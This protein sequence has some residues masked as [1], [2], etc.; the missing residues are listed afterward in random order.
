MFHKFKVSND[1]LGIFYMLLCDNYHIIISDVQYYAIKILADDKEKKH[2]TYQYVGDFK[3]EELQIITSG[4][5]LIYD[6]YNISQILIKRPHDKW[7]TLYDKVPGDGKLVTGKNGGKRRKSHKK[8]K[9][10]K[11]KRTKRS[12]KGTKRRRH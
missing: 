4:Y 5:E 2:I 6:H 10:T 7:S 8:R 12:R 9:G 3:G 11:R 1:L